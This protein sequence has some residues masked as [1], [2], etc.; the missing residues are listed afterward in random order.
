MIKLDKSDIAAKKAALEKVSNQ[1]KSE[2]FG[3]DD[4]IDKVI[5]SIHAWY[6]FP[7]IITRPVIINLWGMTGVGKTQLVRRLSTLL[8][9]HNRFVEVQM[10]GGSMKSSYNSD[11]LSKILA[12]SSIEEGTPGI[13]LLD[14][15]QRFRTVAHDGSDIKVERFQDVWTLLSDGRFSADASMFQ[16]IEMMIAMQEYSKDYAASHPKD[17]EDDEDEPVTPKKPR[18]FKIYPYEAKSLKKTLRLSES[19][20]E[21]MRWE[22]DRITEELAKLKT[23]RTT[24]EID[25]SKLVIFISGNLDN[26]FIGATAA[27]DCDTDADFYHEETKKISTMQ[28]KATLLTQFRPEQVSRLGNN[29][30]IYPSMSRASY[31]QLIEATVNKY[32]NE[33]QNISGIKFTVSQNILDVIY[34]NSV[35]PTQGTRP[36]FSSIHLIFSGLLSNITFWA[37]ENNYDRVS[38]DISGDSA[39]VAKG[40]SKSPEATAVFPITLE[41]TEKKNR[42]TVDFKTFVAVHEAGHAITYA[43]LTGTAP[44]EIKINV[45]SFTGGYVLPSNEN[46][47]VTKK[48]ISNQI[49]VYLAGRAAEMLVF[50]SEDCS[51]GARSDIAKATQLASDY[52]RVHG[53]SEF[54]SVVS[55]KDPHPLSWTTFI[56]ESDRIIEKM[57]NE[58]M[59]RATK[60]IKENDKFFKL[61]VDRLIHSNVIK[62]EEFIGMANDFGFSLKTSEVDEGFKAAWDSYKVPKM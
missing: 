59:E 6:I 41:I 54:V 3:L 1:L 49:T 53:F 39:I 25:Y 48:Q 27:D 51:T 9:F 11:M 34:D 32:I 29:H 8:Q 43:A 24:W 45:V 35:F 13:L 57:M 60:V 30:I 40:N 58:F 12:E 17:D 5:K 42:A 21:I 23:E 28:I 26:A 52:V 20:Q 7:E 18:Q 2:F 15:I 4:V 55:S 61:V 37:I 22:S 44:K 16:E 38:M 56:D 46:S 47:I 31:K 36:V 62:Q 19:V 10:D 14:E 33:M 50:G